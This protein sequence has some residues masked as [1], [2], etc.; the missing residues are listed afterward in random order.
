M[1]ATKQ[2]YRVH[3]ERCVM[4]TML[5]TGLSASLTM[6]ELHGG[7]PDYLWAAI[8]GAVCWAC[9]DLVA[10]LRFR[11]HVVRMRGVAAPVA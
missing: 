7:A 9:A 5:I 11:R 3:Q 10:L 8:I 4:Q 2:R 6:I 1:M